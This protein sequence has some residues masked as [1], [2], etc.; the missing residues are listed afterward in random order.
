MEGARV[1]PGSGVP[2]MPGVVRPAVA[3]EIVVTYDYLRLG[4]GFLELPLPDGSVIEAENAVFEDRGGGNLMWTGEVPGAG[5]ESVLFTV[6]DGH[7][8]GWFGEP[9]GPKYV[10][11]AGP[12]GIGSLSREV[13]PTGD[14]CGVGAGP[15]RDLVRG[16]PSALDRPASV[17][18]GSSANRLDILVLYPEGTEHYWRV[19]GGP[20]VGVRQLGDYLNMVLRNGAIRATANLIPVRWDPK[21]ASHP[22]TRGSHL[23]V[24]AYSTLWHWEFESSVEVDGLRRRHA[25]D[26]IHFVIPPLF[27][28]GSAGGQAGLRS[29]FDAYV[30]TGWS[31]AS[32]YVFAHEI[33]HNL[34]GHHEPAQLGEYFEQSQSWDLENFRPYRYGHTDMTSCARREGHGDNLL[35]PA[36]IMSYG[37]EA[38]N[39][40]DPL[41]FSSSEPFYSSVRHKPNGWTIGVAGTSEVERLFQ[42]TAPVAANSGQARWRLD[43]YPRRVTGARWTDHDTVRLEWS[44]DW[45][46]Q[47]SGQVKLALP[48][49]AND[50]YSWF[51]DRESNPGDPRLHNWSDP[52]VAPIVRA[53]GVQVGVEVSGLR[54]GGRYR[55]AVEGPWRYHADTDRWMRS[56]HSDIFHLEPPGR[57]SGSPAA[58]SDI[59]AR[60]TGPD[61]VRLHWSANSGVETGYEVWYRKWSGMG[62]FAGSGVG[63]Q[64][65][66][67]KVWHRYGEPLPARIRQVDIGGLSAEEEVEVTDGYW[68][69][70]AW[71]QGRKVKVGRYSFAVVAYNDKGW[72]ASETFHLEFMPEPHPAPTES[73]EIT[74]CTVWSRFTGIDLDGYQVQACL[75]TPDG[76]RRRAWDY[77]IAADRSG[78]LYFFDRDDA[79]ILV[80]VRDG[81]AINGH[82]WVFVAPVTTLPF[83]L[84]IQEPG[85]YIEGRRML[86]RYDS[87]RRPQGEMPWSAGNPKDEPAR[88]VSDMTAF[89]CTTAEI[90]AA[91]AATGDLRA[92]DATGSGFGAADLGATVR[93]APL[94]AGAESACEPTRPALTLAGGYRVSMCWETE[95]GK[96]GHA[97]DWGLESERMGLL[98][99]SD[100][101]L[102]DALVKIRDDSE[103]GGNVSVLVAPATTAAFNLRVESPNGYVWRYANRLGE[104][105][106]AVSDLSAFPP[107][108]SP[109]DALLCTGVTCLLQ[110]ERFRVKAWYSKGGG[111]SRKAG[112][113]GAAL[114]ASAGLFSGDGGGPELLVRVVNR[115]R[116][117]GWW[118]V[119]AGVASDADFSVAIRDTETNALK[120]FRPRGR[121]VVDAEAFACT[122]SDSGAM[123]VGPPG[124]PDATCSGATCVLQDG[125]FR[126]KSRYRRESGSSASAAAIPVDLGGEAGLFAFA[127]GKPELVLR[128][129]DTCGTSGY[130]TVYAGAASNADFSVAIRNTATDELKW[131]R[132]RGGQTVVDASA[133][134]CAGR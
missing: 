55:L 92:A 42:E 41:T 115:C 49:G 68:E 30:E 125:L 48:E 118:E 128:I 35:C 76:A 46:S 65:E 11:Y 123:A 134:A 31:F 96:R 57:V 3:A 20:A 58:P 24:P 62:G 127:S 38:G 87:E 105:A 99:F 101:D 78:L 59:G 67:D 60:V 14:W 21:L 1:G 66:P 56:Q 51:W 122:E 129:A 27:F 45:R 131:F 77:R 47:D 22:S 83:R 72:N 40:D 89:P 81:C 54:P 39:D 16:S 103:A 17:A 25:P 37:V 19:I 106:E 109:P 88:T 29:N 13:G 4:M 121:S 114:G 84:A 15:G 64:G 95:N 33:G 73:G 63:A 6:Q 120:W 10:V 107:T 74:D 61:G 130:W 70:D 43:Q 116:T 108:G 32:G 71:V 7:L 98:Y 119:H 34:G 113:I 23:V 94:M 124:D 97:R 80:K 12:D 133:F 69:D 8:V 26:L 100:R 82:R 111:R 86:W 112:A 50:V 102:V 52:N 110:G 9:G 91:R 28:R 126:V 90:A 117:S 5:Y 53:G 36:T 93:R 44:D 75:E 79:E 132:S 104:T 2:G 18:S 85:P